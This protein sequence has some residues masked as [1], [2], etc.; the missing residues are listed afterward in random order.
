MGSRSLEPSPS[1]TDNPQTNNGRR[2]SREAP[3]SGCAAFRRPKRRLIRR[4]GPSFRPTPLRWSRS[5]SQSVDQPQDCLEQ[6]LRHRDLVGLEG[7]GSVFCWQPSL[8]PRIR[9]L[10]A[11][12]GYRNY[13]PVDIRARSTCSQSA[14]ER[15]IKATSVEFCG[16]K[17]CNGKLRTGIRLVARTIAGAPISEAAAPIRMILRVIR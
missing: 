7:S 1:L 11:C 2:G 4:L 6:F 3:H 17:N 10:P 16:F 14:V 5:W 9:D 8:C 13:F 15:A 12:V